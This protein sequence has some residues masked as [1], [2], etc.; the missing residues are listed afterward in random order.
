VDLHGGG[1][2]SGV[3]TKR[4]RV[5]RVGSGAWSLYLP[6][7]WIDSWVPE[8]QEGREVDVRAIGQSLLITPVLQ[9]RTYQ[10][11][12]P[13]R[14]EDVRIRL[15]GAYVRGY[16]RATLVPPEGERFDNDCVTASRDL[17]RHLDERLVAQGTPD[18]I[19][20]RLDPGLSHP[21]VMG[22]ELLGVLGAKVEEA[23]RL[24]KDA[25]DTYGHDPDRTLH[26]LHMLRSIQED[27]IARLFHQAL[28]LVATLEIPLRT[29]T[30]YQLLALAAAELHQV[31]GNCLH[32]AGAILEAYDLELTDLD[33]P[34]SHLLKRVPSPPRVRGL[35]REL[36]GAHADAFAD[37][38]R[39]HE[40]VL[41]ALGASDIERLAELRKE[42]PAA[43]ARH[44]DRLFSVVAER[45]GTSNEPDEALA[46]HTASR[47]GNPLQNILDSL[48]MMS[49]H[50]TALLSARREP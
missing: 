35:A 25:M 31:G 41:E 4:K 36:L 13:V 48:R 22:A 18:Q 12:V 30:D 8:Q 28:R 5:S 20:F 50:G 40:A 15:L 23:L 43:Q 14:T 1:G 2:W 19:G 47:L 26:S 32:M 42:C 10:A 34:R 17:L 45:W 9:D 21:S 29:V 44:Q 6:K 46:A 49:H 27:D 7:K 11:T 37:I 3:E 24:A 16:H 38:L 39:L 33:Y